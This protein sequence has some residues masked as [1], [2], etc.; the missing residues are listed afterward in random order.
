MPNR[1]AYFAGSPGAGKT[2]LLK[3]LAHSKYRIVNLGSMMLNETKTKKRDRMR[4][5]DSKEI[6]ELRKR[7]LRKIA[8][9]GGDIIIDS[10][11]SVEQR[12]RYI[13]GITIDDLGI[14]KNLKS[15]VYVD[16]FTEDIVKRRNADKSRNREKE[17]LEL[18]DVQRLINL[19]IL[20]TCAAYLDVPIYVV[21]NKQGELSSS[22]K[23]LRNDLKETFI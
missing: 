13:P 10:H 4:F 6:T 14:I 12:G 3:G 18:I 21:L 8:A 19:S 15:F 2:T 5:M 20:S 22:L 9:M 17:R 16:S 7:V 1:I 23:E 11:A